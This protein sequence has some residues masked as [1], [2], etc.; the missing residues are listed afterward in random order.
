VVHSI[1]MPVPE[2][3]P[4]K[5]APTGAVDSMGVPGRFCQSIRKD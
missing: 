1:E 3:R 5:A 4:D 2:P